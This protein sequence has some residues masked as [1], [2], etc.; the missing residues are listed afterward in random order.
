MAQRL[1][2]PLVGVFDIELSDEHWAE[3]EKSRWKRRAI[4]ILRFFFYFV[5]VATGVVFVFVVEDGGD[6]Y[7]DWQGAMT[8]STYEEE[9]SKP[10]K[11][12][13]FCFPPL[14]LPWLCFRDCPVSAAHKIRMRTRKRDRTQKEKERKEVGSFPTHCPVRFHKSLLLL[15]PDGAPA[16]LPK[17]FAPWS[18][19]RFQQPFE[20]AY[21]QKFG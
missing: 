4:N 3:T 14:R 2:H 18:V 8:T 20:F 7:S 1:Y 15:E 19:A 11:I 10:K 5:F 9:T 6:F 12:I 17:D 21:F 16:S 13:F